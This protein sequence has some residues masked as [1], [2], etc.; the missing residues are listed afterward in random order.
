MSTYKIYRL[1]VSNSIFINYTYLI[2]DNLTLLAAIVDPSW[3]LELV[4]ETIQKLNVKIKSILLTHSHHDHVN[5]VPL[6]T[7]NYEPD[8]FMHRTEIRDYQFQCKNLKGF[9]D[10]EVLILGNTS[11]ICIWTPGH[12]SGSSCFLLTDDL[13]TGDTLFSEGVG[14]C[15]PESGGNPKK[16]FQSTQRLKSIIRDNIFIHP[17]HAY[18]HEPGLTFQEL[19]NTN[20]YLHLDNEK[21]FVSFR[22]REHQPPILDWYK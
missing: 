17:G 5:L 22:M 16:L 15:Q 13:F 3:D 14:I 6:L 11:I 8:V 20:L 19:Y 1:K 18:F 21:D 4:A 9:S 12:T 10:R 2:V 7:E